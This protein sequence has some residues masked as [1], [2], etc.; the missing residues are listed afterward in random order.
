[1]LQGVRPV[2]SLALGPVLSFCPVDHPKGTVHPDVALV[3]ANDTAVEG[4]IVIATN[5]HEEATE[6]DIQN[7]FGDYGEI[8]NLHLNL[9]RRTGYVKVSWSLPVHSVICS[10]WHSIL[11]ETLLGICI[12]RIRV[13]GGSRSRH[14]RHVRIS[15]ARANA[16]LRFRI[17][18]TSRGVSCPFSVLLSF[19]VPRRRPMC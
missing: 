9:E 18:T 5:V 4:W 2:L 3:N 1:M 14:Q 12:G 8:Q 15:I 10:W 11:T 19:F 13:E 7:T 6:E 16:V 17:R